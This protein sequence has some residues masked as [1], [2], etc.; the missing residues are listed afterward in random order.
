[1]SLLGQ[2]EACTF[3]QMSLRR[4]HDLCEIEKFFLP[5]EKT[6]VANV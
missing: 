4:M 1:M 5:Q 3:Q 2:W 6:G